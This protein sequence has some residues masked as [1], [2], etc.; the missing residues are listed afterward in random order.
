MINTI[1]FDLDGT[2]LPF[3]Q[4]DFLKAYFGG[5]CKNM[6]PFGYASDDAIKALWHGSKAMIKNDGTVINAVRFWDGF[7]E[8][9]GEGVRELQAPLDAYYSGEYDEVKTILREETPA[10]AIVDTLKR[11]GYTIVL[12]TNPLFP[13]IAQEKRMSWA[14][15]T[16]DD[17]ALVTDYENSRFCK[18]NPKYYEEI[19]QKLGK[20][21][22]ECLMV[23][24][25]VGEDMIAKELGMAVY[26][27]TGYVENPKE[28]PIEDYPQGSLADFAAV[29]EALPTVTE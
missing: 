24:N 20:A 5:L 11:K 7:A 12:A 15:L 27:V 26:L 21:P 2:L 1:L 8:V 28:L 29:V 23:G 25:S 14:G 22:E 6:A 13:R 18:P 17:F 3:F 16:P 9:L 4:E 10:K 19:L